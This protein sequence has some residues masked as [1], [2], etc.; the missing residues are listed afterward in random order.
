MATSFSALT[1]CSELFYLTTVYMAAMTSNN[2]NESLYKQSLQA[3]A[4]LF[5]EILTVSKSLNIEYTSNNEIITSS[6]KL[7]QLVD[8]LKPY[9]LVFIEQGDSIW[10]EYIEHVFARTLE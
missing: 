5:D 1:Y 2:M 7:S 3:T 6:L 8:L 10:R 4:K 9:V